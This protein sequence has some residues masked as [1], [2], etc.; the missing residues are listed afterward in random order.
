M[1]DQFFN[2]I[3]QLLVNAGPLAV[4]LIGI[5]EEVFFPIP[6]NLVFLTV[7]FFILP[8]TFSFW[9]AFTKA[10]ID[11]AILGA[12]GMTVGAFFIY[13]IF[14]FGGKLFID[15]YGK[16]LGISWRQVEKIEQRFTAGYADEITIFTLRALP[17]WPVTVVSALCGLM[18]ISWKTFAVYSYLGN[19]VRVTILGLLGW[20][21]GEA[22]RFL[23]ERLAQWEKYGAAVLVIIFLL[24][25]VY[26]YQKRKNSVAAGS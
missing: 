16:Y 9:S 19:V 3:Q 22:Y 6:S 20:Q 26:V 7:G 14:Y 1:A 18:R 17:I 15:N 2:L 25:V 11:L 21:L 13:G 4:F 24:L 23:G 8:P 10:L 12:L 5:F